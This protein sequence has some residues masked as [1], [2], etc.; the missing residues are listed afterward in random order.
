MNSVLGHLEPQGVFSAFE[1]LCQIPHGSYDTKAIS[2]YCV[3]FAKERGLKYI[4]DDANNVIIIK[5]ASAGYEAAKPVILQGHLDMVCEKTAD[6]SHDFKADGLKLL[7]DGDWITA[8]GTTLGGDDGIAIAYCLAILDDDSLAHPKLYMVFTTEEETGMEG[9]HA[10]DLTPVADAAYMINLDS[11]DEG[12]ILAGCAGGARANATY[13]VVRT[14]VSGLGCTLAVS[15]I[16]G[17][18]SGQE[19][20]R[21]GAN[22]T[23]LLAD[24][25]ADLSEDFDFDITEIT[26]GSKDNV[27]PKASS[28][29]LVIN[30]ADKDALASRLAEL[31][32]FYQKCYGSRE[33]GIHLTLTCEAEGEFSVFDKA[34]KDRAIY[35][36]TQTPCG[37]QSMSFDIQGLTETSLN[38]GILYTKEDSLYMSFALRSSV[39]AAK[40]ALCQ[41]LRRFTE[42]LGGVY[43]ESSSYPAW[44]YRPQSALRD[45]MTKIFE[46]MYGKTP[47]VEAIHAGLEC[48]LI[49]NKLPNLDIVSIGPDM[50]DIHTPD[51]R[52]SIASTARTWD[53]L[54]EILKALR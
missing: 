50:K 27:I 22:A 42:Y 11:E 45:L 35:A 53:Y 54:L 44:E 6:S 46:D 37:V 18:H 28:V 26:G 33:E 49:S 10:I 23:V 25:L 39:G 48:G 16:H 1:K 52:L 21:F 51:E 38:L 24:V 41:K 47:V 15:G 7:I 36:I 3:A 30:P 19:I 34:S 13:P 31:Q 20:N 12:I 2:D 17:G 32:A 9:A 40:E 14:T 43:H 4:Q 5:E 8:D 29:K